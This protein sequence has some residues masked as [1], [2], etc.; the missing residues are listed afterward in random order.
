MSTCTDRCYESI[1]EEAS[2]LNLPVSAIRNAHKWPEKGTYA[3]CGACDDQPG[4]HERDQRVISVVTDYQ[5]G[6]Y[7]A[8]RQSGAQLHRLHQSYGLVKNLSNPEAY[9]CVFC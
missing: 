6:R 8:G 3:E 1:T 7:Q 2:L 5:A 9:Q 4:Q